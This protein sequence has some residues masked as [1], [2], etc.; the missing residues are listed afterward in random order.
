MTDRSI[1]I[2]DLGPIDYLIVE[3]SRAEYSGKGLTLVVDLVDRRL[4]RVLDV[5]FVQRDEHGVAS[6]LSIDDLDADGALGLSVFE[7]ASGGLLG[8]DDVREAASCLQ[9]G[10]AGMVVVYENLW[11][12]PLART[13]R[14]EGAEL[15][16]S[17]RIPISA[18]LASMEEA[19]RAQ[20]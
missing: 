10:S 1:G 7:G 11:A 9:R 18:L 8:R 19:E 12:V 5:A 16:A 17:G 13:L 20:I 3:F 14:L 4:I 6:A 2:D 15:V